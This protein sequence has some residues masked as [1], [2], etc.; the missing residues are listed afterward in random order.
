MLDAKRARR[1][2]QRVRRDDGDDGAELGVGGL[3]ELAPG[4]DVFEQL[5]DWRS[6]IGVY[7]KMAKVAGPRAEAARSEANKI[8]LQKFIWE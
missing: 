8:R 6:A 3:Q 4:G 5:A 7:E 2:R 1:Q